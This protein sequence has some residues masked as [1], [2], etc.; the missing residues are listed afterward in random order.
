MFRA[1]KAN[2]D[3]LDHIGSSVNSSLGSAV[4]FELELRPSKIQVP[5]NAVG[6]AVEVVA[7]AGMGV[8]VKSTGAGLDGEMI[9]PGTVLAIFPGLVHLNEPLPL[10]SPTKTAMSLSSLFD[11]NKTIGIKDEYIHRE[12]LPDPNYQLL[13]RLDG[14][15]IDSRKP[16]TSAEL[17]SNPY[18]VANRINHPPLDPTS[19]GT[20]GGIVRAQAPNVV[21]LRYNFEKPGNGSNDGFPVELTPFIPNEYAVKPHFPWLINRSILM[22]SSIV[23][24][25]SYIK[26]GDELYVDYRLGPDLPAN[27]VPSWYRHVDGEGARS[28]L[29]N[30]PRSEG[31]HEGNRT[32]AVDEDEDDDAPEGVGGN[33][34]ATPFPVPKEPEASKDAPA[35]DGL[36]S[37]AGQQRGV[38][39][40]LGKEERRRLK[41]V[42]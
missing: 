13:M 11:F 34:W 1:L 12:L 15:F 3:N 42:R 4:G 2:H 32:A 17:L 19:V 41:V 23:V 10:T 26:P 20:A 21:Q 33:E 39:G 22:H 28:R 29:S 8:F 9:C 24:A 37:I 7:D 38:P 30:S 5:Q 25:C 35:A 40:Q 18:A 31:E 6:D 16:C 14:I 36:P 27:M